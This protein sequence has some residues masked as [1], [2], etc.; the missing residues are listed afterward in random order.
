MD[1]KI[2]VSVIIPVYMV[3]DYIEDCLESVINQTYQKLEIILV[4]D[5]SIDNCPKICDRYAEKDVRIKVI[6]KSNGGLSDARNKGLDVMT[7]DAVFFL[8]SDDWIE[9]DTIESMVKTYEKYDV[10]IVC[11]GIRN[12]YDNYTERFNGIKEGLFTKEE[13]LYDLV[14]D[15]NIGVVA[16]NKLYDSKLF[17]DIRY[18]VGRIHEDEFVIHR[19]LLKCKNVYCKNE[20]YYNYRRRRDGSITTL[21]N[22]K[23]QLDFMEAYLDR[24]VTLRNNGFI[25]LS[26]KLACGLVFWCYE[27]AI[28]VDGIWEFLEN[29][30]DKEIIGKINRL[31]ARKIIS[32]RCHSLNWHLKLWVKSQIIK[33]LCGNSLRCTNK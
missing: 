22:K 21:K 15:N 23:S 25:E 10:E 26:D 27:Y 3:E 14:K 20:L 19:L 33:I 5:G 17:A 1:E 29:P 31:S 30:Q 12:I 11:G 24:M 7:G 32:R 16:V 4:D 13:A 9:K 6:H 18:P 8:D 2:L 28:K